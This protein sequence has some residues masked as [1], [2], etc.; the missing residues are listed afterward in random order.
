MSDKITHALTATRSEMRDL[1]HNPSTLHFVLI[2]KGTILTTNDHSTI[3]SPLLSLLKEFQDVFPDELP[4]GLTPLRSIEHRIDLISGAPFQTM[5][6]TTQ[7]WMRQRKSNIK[8]MIF[9]KK[10]MF[11]KAYLLVSFR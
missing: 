6:R 5:P 3:P 10:G 9:Y 4:H 11:V 2:C 7:L 8:F 1:H